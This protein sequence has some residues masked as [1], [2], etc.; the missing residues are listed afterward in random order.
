VYESITSGELSNELA[1]GLDSYSLP[2]VERGTAYYVPNELLGE[3]KNVSIIG[4]LE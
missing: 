4:R 3:F 1:D 2:G